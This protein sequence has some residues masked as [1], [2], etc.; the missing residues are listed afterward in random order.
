MHSALMHLISASSPTSQDDANR[1]SAAWRLVDML[2]GL[3]PDP[4]LSAMVAVVMRKREECPVLVVTGSLR[5]EV[6]YVRDY[7]AAIGIQAEQRALHEPP[8][9]D[10]DWTS[11]A[12]YP[13][14]VTTPDALKVDESRLRNAALVY[15]TPPQNG[16][17]QAWL[18]S[19]LVAGVVRSVTLPVV[20]VSRFEGDT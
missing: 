18:R 9:A 14:I 10:T 17:D 4:R 20:D 19:A 7:L 2:E 16:T 8:V 15:F 12:P 3:G 1:T 5:S 6:E 11:G 13:I